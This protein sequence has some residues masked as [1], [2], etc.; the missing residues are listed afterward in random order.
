[1]IRHYGSLEHQ[2]AIIA[3]IRR[4][5]PKLLS[6]TMDTD[7][8][9]QTTTSLVGTHNTSVEEVSDMIIAL[10]NGV[11]VL[12]E[13]AKRLSIETNKLSNAIENLNNEYNALK[14][15][16]REQNTYLDGI[17]PKQDALQQEVSTLQQTI[18]DS[19]SI[20]YDGTYTWRISGFRE[21]MG[22]F[23]IEQISF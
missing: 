9:P 8:F 19:Q 2:K 18:D 16:I 10:E 22:E 14:L 1:M 5:V 4:D 11:D 7:H 3:F 6:D 20:S 21:K 12:N 13:D 17:K 15:S 23:F